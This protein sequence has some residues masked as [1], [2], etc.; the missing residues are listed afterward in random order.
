MS[1]KKGGSSM[2]KKLISLMSAIIICSGI[3]GCDNQSTEYKNNTENNTESSN[4]E[5]E[6]NY[7]LKFFGYNEVIKEETIKAKIKIIDKKY[8]AS[9]STMIFTGKASIPVHHPA[10]YKVTCKYKGVESTINDKDFYNK[11][12]INEEVTINLHVKYYEDNTISFE[13][14]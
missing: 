13:I 10:E 8:R 5:N 6:T 4:D 1:H 2:N 14:E 3:V 9:Y 11:V 7:I 12:D